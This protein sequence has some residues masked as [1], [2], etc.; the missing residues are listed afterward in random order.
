MRDDEIIIASYL[1]KCATRYYDDEFVCHLRE[2]ETVK[3]VI[4]NCM[5]MMV[6][7]MFQP[8]KDYS[9][10]IVHREKEAR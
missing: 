8:S 7:K 1:F 10:R 5:E 2:N 3:D 9:A 6:N 4:S